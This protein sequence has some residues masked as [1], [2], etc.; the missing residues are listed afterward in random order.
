VPAALYPQGRFLVLISVRGQVDPWAIVQL[1]GL[2]QLKKI[3]LIGTRT[4]DL[5]ASS[6]VPQPTT[7]PRATCDAKIVWNYTSIS[8]RDVVLL[9]RGSVFFILSSMTPTWRPWS[10]EIG[11]A[12]TTHNVR[13][14]NLRFS[15]GRILRLRFSGTWRPL[16]RYIVPT[17]RKNLLPPSSGYSYTLA[18]E[19]AGTSEM[20]IPICL[21]TLRDTA[22]AD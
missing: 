15:L 7:L 20:F 19:Q 10:W 18:I 5:P 2:G 9:H 17:F 14:R 16:V 12:I 22:L 4:R 1:E 11:L 13:T 6:T 21:I 3:H 8:L